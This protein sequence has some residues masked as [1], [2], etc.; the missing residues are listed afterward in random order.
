MHK[1]DSIENTYPAVSRLTEAGWPVVAASV[2]GLFFH[3]GSLLVISFSL[4]IKPPGEQFNWM[5][6]QVSLAFT[7]AC[8]T[9]L[10]SMPL[11]GWLTDRFG[12]RWLIIISMSL[13]G[14]LFASLSFLTPHLW[15][16]YAV[17][18][19]LR[20]SGPGTSAVP[21]ASLISRWFTAGRGLAPGVMMCGT[22]TG[23]I[24]GLC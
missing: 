13:F 24:I 20:L 10:S 15:F 3:F 11:V 16:L 7:L 22:G 12:A 2:I 8:L 23:G 21:R 14:A 4:F 9:T 17:L 6:T 5:R 19:I 1:T 18:A